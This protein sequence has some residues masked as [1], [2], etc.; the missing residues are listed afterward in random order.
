MVLENSGLGE[1]SGEYEYEG[2]GAFFEAR[3][4]SSRNALS[5]PDVPLDERLPLGGTTMSSSVCCRSGRAVWLP[6][7]LKGESGGFFC[8]APVRGR[9]GTLTAAEGAT[10][11]LPLRYNASRR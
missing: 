9:V 3:R 6:P 7:K 1:S 11:T 10:L 4:L 8:A 2:S 5:E